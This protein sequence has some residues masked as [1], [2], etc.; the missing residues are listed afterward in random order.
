MRPVLRARRAT[1]VVAVAVLAGVLVVPT[2]AGAEPAAPATAS[3]D[4]SRVTLI[5][6][7][8]AV[9]EHVAP[10][11]DAVTMEPA[12]G[13][14]GIRIHTVELDGHTLLLPEDAMAL[15][16]AGTV[17]REVFDLTTL[18]ADGFADEE[19]AALPLLITSD[20]DAMTIASLMATFFDS[21]YSS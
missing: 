14:E 11:R 1:P 12:P 5:T 10:G 15:V 16:A 9:V 18:L 19:T 2:P 4:V 17:Q 6:G 8:V 13:R 20:P 7:D 21:E 3:A